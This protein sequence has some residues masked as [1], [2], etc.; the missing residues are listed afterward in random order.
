MVSVII[1][2]VLSAHLSECLYF[3]NSDFLEENL[4]LAQQIKPQSNRLKQIVR[5]EELLR[6]LQAIE[7]YK[8]DTRFKR[9]AEPVPFVMRQEERWLK[10]T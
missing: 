7:N 6:Q 9:M 8:P 2:M 5:L 4:Q 1:L 10:F 3:G